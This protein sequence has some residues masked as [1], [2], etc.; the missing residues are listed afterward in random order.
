VDTEDGVL[1]SQGLAEGSLLP[2]TFD[3]DAFDHTRKGQL[4]AAF[5]Q[6]EVKRKAERAQ[7]RRLKAK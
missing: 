4:E 3:A 7:M 2:L 1:A 5:D 6:K